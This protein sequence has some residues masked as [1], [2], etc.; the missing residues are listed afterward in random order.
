[1]LRN[2]IGA[3]LAAALTASACGTDSD[4]GEQTSD[5]TAASIVVTSSAYAEVERIPVEFTCDGEGTQPPYTL[6]GLPSETMSVAVV[7]EAMVPQGEFTHW[8]QFDMPP[9]SEIPEDAIDSGKPGS[10]FLQTI[11]YVPPCPM[12]NAV[13][14]YKLQVFA[15]D[16]FLD[17]E[18]GV[19]KQVLLAALKGH[20]VGLGELSGEYSRS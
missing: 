6:S 8:V 18:E 12:G 11:G 13:G 20:V 15:V 5:V 14:R 2:T 3:V 10:A 9:D 1:M 4:P 17:L 7:M 19:S 16:S